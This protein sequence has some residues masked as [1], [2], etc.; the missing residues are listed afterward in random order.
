M[1]DQARAFWVTAPGC[2]EI[3]NE[4]LDTPGPEDVVVCAL[5]SGISRGTEAL[6]FA[7]RVPP[8][9]R[10]RMRAPFQR[11]DFP[12]PVKYGYSLVG[13][14]ENGPDGLSG[15]TVFVLHPHQTRLVVPARSVHV[16]P[17]AVPPARAVLA[18]NLETAVNG[19]WDARPHLGD[20]IAVIGGGTVGCLA[21]WL[22]SRI[23]GCEV[24]LIDLNPRRASV[25]G[26]L[27]L[28]FAEPSAATREA[29]LV[30]HASGTP[31]GLELSLQ[32]AA[33]DATIVELSWFGDRT[34]PLPLGEAFHSK[35]LTIASSQ[36]GHVAPSQRPRWDNRRRMALV[37][38]LLREAE[39]DALITGESDFET[40]PEIMARLARSPGDALCHRIRYS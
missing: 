36:V 7:G 8:S 17:D 24:E 27:K 15:R 5:Y 39:L 26:A 31:E 30:I 3:R 1:P 12:A 22:V 35:R 10:E 13:R 32:L 40:M 29:D 16:L 6:V 23:P 34:V 28:R 2:G 4:P 19:V 20:R 33:R 18:A 21:A 38:E 37:L 14:V 9:E 11:G 25:A